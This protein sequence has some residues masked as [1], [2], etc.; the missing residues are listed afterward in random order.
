MVP[1]NTGICHQVNLEYLSKVVIARDGVAFPDTLVGTDSHTP[2]VN[3]IGV[4][5]WGVGGIEAEAAMLGQPIPMLIPRVVGLR[6]AGQLPEGATAT[7]LLLTVTELLR[8][9]GVVGKFVEVFGPGVE[10]VPAESRAAIGNMS[11][12]YGSTITVFPIDAE[13]LRYLRLSGRTADGGGAGRGVR[14]G[15]GHVAR[16]DPGAGLLRDR[17]ARPAHGGAVDGRAVPAPGPGAARPGQGDV[18]G[19][20]RRARPRR[21]PHRARRGVQGVVPGQRPAGPLRAAR[22]Q[23]RARPHR[24]RRPPSPTSAPAT[25]VPVK[26]A[27]GEESRSTTASVTIAA[28]TSCTNTSNPSVMLAAGLVARKAVERGLRRQPWVKTSLAPGS[29]VVM[30]YYERAGLTPYLDKLGF[31]LVGF[32]CTTCIGNSG[33]LPAEISAAVNEAG[34][35]VAGVLSGNR[36]FEGRVN[37]DVRLNYLASPPL[38]VA[39]ALAGHHGLGPLHRADRRGHGRPAGLP[40]GHLADHRRGGRRPWPRR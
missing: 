33:P 20:G 18:P 10:A 31:E 29:K 35:S 8:R 6:L 17:R 1:P 16:P 11:P 39:Y 36:N 5:G 7:D 30:D 21:R 2:T 9:Q 40:A 19:R 14:Q 15:T 23:R 26:L 3:G 25:Q 27:S 4:V 32:G 22:P 34:L 13:T 37:P 24:R 28:I 12:E 38:V